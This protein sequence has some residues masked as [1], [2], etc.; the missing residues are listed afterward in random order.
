MKY[1]RGGGLNNRRLFFAVLEAG[2]SKCYRFG[3]CLVR[4]V[5]F[6]AWKRLPTCHLLTWQGEKERERERQTDR[7]RWRER[8]SSGH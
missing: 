6:L 2:K 4:R 1:H 7:E 3:Y 5:L 8:V